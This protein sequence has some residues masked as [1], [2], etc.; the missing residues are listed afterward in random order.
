MAKDLKS[1]SAKRRPVKKRSPLSRGTDLA[2]TLPKV[3]V[4]KKPRLAKSV[5]KKPAAKKPAKSNTSRKPASDARKLRSTARPKT[6]Q[7]QLI[8]MP[9]G[10][11][12]KLVLAVNNTQPATAK[13]K[14]DRKTA[15]KSKRSKK[16]ELVL[17][18]GLLLLGALGIIFFSLRAVALPSPP[19]AASAVT[20]AI[21]APPTPVKQSLPHSTPTRLSI[22]SIQLDTDLT[23]IGLR[24]DGSI[25]VPEQYTM[26]GW[27]KQSPTPG[28]IGPSIIVGHLDNVHGIAVFWRLHEL[29]PGQKITVNRADGSVAQF[30]IT[31]IQQFPQGNF[32]TSEVYGNINYAGLRLIT[33][34][35]SF[36]LLTRHYS[37]NTVIFASLVVSDAS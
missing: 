17:S 8:S 36:N 28:E 4:T 11:G 16:Q 31:K 29:T 32:P 18:G 25:E 23:T 35:G 3:G 19:L 14:Q 27:Y 15:S 7:K 2:S 6:R 1:K 30:V 37:D 26:A 9:L 5:P 33:C 12:R 20:R 22:P 10:R 13:G 34:G 24:P 21:A